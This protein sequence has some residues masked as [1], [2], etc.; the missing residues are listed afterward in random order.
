[1]QCD[2]MVVL[3]YHKFRLARHGLIVRATASST[4]VSN[5]A[6]AQEIAKR[7]RLTENQVSQF[8]SVLLIS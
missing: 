8:A 2:H 7:Y 4:R 1:M 3:L 5:V 6:F